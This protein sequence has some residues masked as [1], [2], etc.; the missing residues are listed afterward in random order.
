[1]S[2]QQE[3]RGGF[4]ALGAFIILAPF[5]YVLSVGPVAGLALRMGVNNETLERIYYPVVW[6]HENTPLQGPIKIY[7]NFWVGE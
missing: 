6:L 2:E 3:G 5:I 7:I 4:S 1:M